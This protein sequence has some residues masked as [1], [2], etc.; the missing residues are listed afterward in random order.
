MCTFVDKLFVYIIYMFLKATKIFGVFIDWNLLIGHFSH[1]LAFVQSSRPLWGG[2]K[3]PFFFLGLETGPGKNWHR[4]TKFQ[5]EMVWLGSKCQ[6]RVFWRCFFLQV[7]FFYSFCQLSFISH[8]ASQEKQFDAMCCKMI[9]TKQPRSS[10]PEVL[11]FW[12]GKCLANG[13]MKQNWVA[14][15]AQL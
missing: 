2:R 7:C 13:Q 5:G 4:A 12:L 1:F 14:E 6:K 10:C 15:V 8:I 9:D 3:F 11:P